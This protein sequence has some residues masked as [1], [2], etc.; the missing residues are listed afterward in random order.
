[1]YSYLKWEILNI[2]NNKLDI[3]AQNTGIWFEVFVSGLTVSSLR[4][5]EQTELFIY[6]NKTEN[7]EDLFGFMNL[8]EKLLFKNLLKISWV[9][10]KMAINI[11]S[12]WL[13]TLLKAIEEW[14][15]KMLTSISWVGK[16]I[17]LKIILEMKNNVAVEDIM[18]PDWKIELQP[19]WNVE[20]INTL[21]AM[22]YDKKAV[23]DVLKNLPEWVETIQ[24]KT[25]YSIRA[26]GRK[27]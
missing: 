10:W 22:W 6:H 8:R 21:T 9:W 3:L 17:A 20:I 19:A 7:S 13:N 4:I 24:E 5:W 14:D 15:E 12:L 1:M 18:K 23:E 25:I 11:L 16:K 2:E 26:L 27:N